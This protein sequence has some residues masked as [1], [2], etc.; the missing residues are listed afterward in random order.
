M[1][2]E[3]VDITEKNYKLRLKTTYRNRRNYREEK[4]CLR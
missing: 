3:L 1:V 4:G 2:G